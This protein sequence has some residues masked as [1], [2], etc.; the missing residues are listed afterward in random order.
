MLH[1]KDSAEDSLF[2]ESI[3]ELPEPGD[4]MMKL[5]PITKGGGVGFLT[6]SSAHD[7]LNKSLAVQSGGDHRHHR[8]S[9]NA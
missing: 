1:V 7:I 5:S 8:K 4:E 3:I 6:N 2:K 9:P